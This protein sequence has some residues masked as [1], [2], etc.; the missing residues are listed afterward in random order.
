MFVEER[1]KFA[2]H[3]ADQWTEVTGRVRLSRRADQALFAAL[4]E[5]RLHCA[6]RGFRLIRVTI[7]VGAFQPRVYA[8]LPDARRPRVAQP[9]P[10]SD[11]S[12]KMTKD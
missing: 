10:R 11:A 7:L 4:T 12:Y 5:P 2:A 9:H 1:I 8:R 3:E 6:K